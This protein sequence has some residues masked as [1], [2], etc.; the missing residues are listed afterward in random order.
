[1][2]TDAGMQVLWHR[3]PFAHVVDVDYDTGDEELLEDGRIPRHVEAGSM[4][5]LSTA[6]RWTSWC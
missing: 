2:A 5:P 1:V 3:K 4:V 6:N